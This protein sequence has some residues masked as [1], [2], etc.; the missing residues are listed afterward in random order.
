MAG[1]PVRI[2]QSKLGL[3]ADGQFGPATEQALKAYQTAHGLEADGI[4]GPD[5]FLALDLP[6]LILLAVGSRGEAVKKLQA[7]L[8][9]AADG[10]FGAGT[11]T[12]LKAFQTKNGLDVDGMAGPVTLQKI[13]AFA[14]I[15][16]PAVVEKALSG[17][18]VPSADSKPAAAE[19][20]KAPHK[21]LWQT[22][23]SF[24]S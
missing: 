24:F 7:A 14:A 10:V 3:A 22:I 13:S 4:A 1:E 2:L 12:A 8:G 17:P 11:E 19:L 23:T 9:V 6:E 20:A 21:S 5:T 18:E 15:I 16:T